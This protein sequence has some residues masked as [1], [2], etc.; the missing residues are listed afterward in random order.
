MSDT[1]YNGWVNYETWL[2]N[3]WN[4]GGMEE[5]ELCEFLD[6]AE[7]KYDWETQRDR[8][9]SDLEN[10][11]S[12][13]VDE[14]L[15]ELS[16]SNGLLVDLL[17]AAISKVDYREIAENWIDEIYDEWLANNTEEDEDTEKEE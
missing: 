13:R 17:N 12:E 14:D 7:P 10:Y 15:E 3:I 16:L 6:N 11:L 5:S 1:T 8:A 9:I 4:D 2:Y